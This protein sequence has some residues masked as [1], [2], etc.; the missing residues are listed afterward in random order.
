M[1]KHYVTNPKFNAELLEK[2]FFLLKFG[3]YFGDKDAAETRCEKKEV[4]FTDVVMDEIIQCQKISEKKC[5]TTQE[6]VFETHT[7]KLIASTASKAT[8]KAV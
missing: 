6:T 2:K 1:L 7:V 4:D 3:L 8:S 5:Y